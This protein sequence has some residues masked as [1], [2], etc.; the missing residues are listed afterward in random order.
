MT[1]SD[2]TGK[3]GAETAQAEMLANRL[4]K[5]FRHLKKWARRTGAEMFRLYDRD[6]PEIPLVLDWYGDALAG[7]LYKRPYEK[8]D[9]E[10]Y[11]WLRRMGEAAAEA[12]DIDPRRVF[13]KFRERQRGAAQYRRM[14]N[15]SVIREVGEGGLRFRVNLSDYLDTGLF[16]D[17]RRL[18]ALVR[19]GAAGKRVLNLFCYTA[20]FSV[21]AA[22]G[23]AAEID[24]VDLSNTYLAWGLENFRL[25]GFTG[26]MVSERAFR[27]NPR[28]TGPAGLSYRAPLPRFRF[29]RADAPVFLAAAARAGRRWD[30]I[31]LDPPA[32]SNS[33]KMTAAL[34]IQRDHPGLIQSALRLLA[35]G[36]ALWF[37]AKA[38]HFRLR[39]EELRTAEFPGLRIEDMT[40]RLT[41][42]DFRGK[43]IPAC[44][45]FQL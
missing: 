17:L 10:E 23:G 39:P 21:Y 42:E 40:D 7:A 30:M 13:I 27:E 2:H 14:G 4:R 15:H 29:I 31:I 9:A 35:P 45:L 24:S 33:K 25:N 18:R 22:A 12:L 3:N 43:K 8:D 44:Y 26:E 19:E 20:S 38:R 36:G 5:R 16:P 37:S 41:D 32:F 6:I 11:Q 34:D 1:P 28:R